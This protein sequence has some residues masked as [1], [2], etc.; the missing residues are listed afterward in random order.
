MTTQLSLDTADAMSTLDLTPTFDVT[1]LPRKIEELLQRTENPFHQAMLRN[2][3]R[4]ALLEISG[5]WDQILVPELT[6]DQP[7]YRI[8]DRDRMLVLSGRDEVLGFYREIA[9][10]RQNVM[11]ARALTMSVADHGIIT[12]AVWNHMVP[13]SLLAD[14]DVDADPDGHYIMSH[15]IF[16]IFV[17]TRDAKLIGERVYD[18]PSTYA[19]EKIDAADF[20]TPE[21]ARE[22]LAPFLARATL[23]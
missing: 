23:H 3:F 11:G 5:Y 12:E 22:A 9:E 8:G 13:G 6:I 2:F 1:F 20:V 21:L 19:Y 10:T 15:N 14:H 17:Y 16:Q 4:H 18:D 7:Q